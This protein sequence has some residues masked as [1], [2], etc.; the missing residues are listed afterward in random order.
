MLASILESGGYR[1]GAYTS[2]HIV[3]FTERFRV[4]YEE[5]S[6]S[7]VTAALLRVEVARQDVPLTY[8]EF[9]TLAAFVIFEEENID[10]AVMEV[11]MGGRLDAV[12]I[13][14]AIATLITNISLDHI[15][16]LGE[17]RDEIAVEKAGLIHRGVPVVIGDTDPPSVLETSADRLGAECYL[18]GKEFG[19]CEGEAGNWTW[20]GQEGNRELRYENLPP[21]L[22]GW[23]EQLSNAS[24][25]LQVLTCIAREFSLE[26][27]DYQAG[28]SRARILGRSQLISRNP[29]ILIDVGHNPAALHAL[30]GHIES[31]GLSGRVYGIFSMLA[32]K[33]VE[34]CVREMGGIVDS[35]Y[36]TRTGQERGMPLPELFDRVSGVLEDITDLAGRD[37]ELLTVENP[38]DA[39]EQAMARLTEQD[40]LVVFGSF[41]IVGDII[42]RF[43]QTERLI[44]YGRQ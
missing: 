15:A 7:Q 4:N 36:V 34:G 42:P 13:V 16:W 20:W 1:T 14:P 24:C 21:P 39:V 32:D 38:G 31:F 41:Y 29:H 19:Y 26:E 22:G 28:L 30:C 3:N 25:V 10:I 17:S 2:P 12:N 6:E 9:A 44:A 5:Q 35:W 11:G 18:A 8:F 40:C 23:E 37:R 33:D 27:K 43:S